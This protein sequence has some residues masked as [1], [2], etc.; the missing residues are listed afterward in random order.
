VAEQESMRSSSNA[1]MALPT[2]LFTT[3]HAG[4]VPGIGCPDLSHYVVDRECVSAARICR[5]DHEVLELP[6]PSRG[7]AAR[8]QI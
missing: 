8:G 7:V 5:I 1:R 6:T 4:S 2:I 3:A